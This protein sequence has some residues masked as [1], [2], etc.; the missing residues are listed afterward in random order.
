MRHSLRRP[1]VSKAPIVA[2]LADMDAAPSFSPSCCSSA[3]NLPL[4][5]FHI[6]TLPLSVGAAMYAPSHVMLT[7]CNAKVKVL[8]YPPMTLMLL[9]VPASH[10]CIV[11]SVA[12]ETT[13]PPSCDTLTANTPPLCPCS[14][15]VHL[16]DMRSH[17]ITVLSLNPPDTASVPSLHMA[18]SPTIPVCPFI[19]TST[20]PVSTFHTC[21]V[22]S[23]PP[24]THRFPSSDKLTPYRQL[25]NLLS[26]GSFSTSTV[27]PLSTFHT[28]TV[29]SLLPDARSFP[30]A[31]KL[32][33]Q[34]M[35][36]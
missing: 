11:L 10:T 30:P 7:E 8:E 9:P 17:I 35:S 6:H 16:P 24:A 13:R 19:S 4:S 25:D 20:S 29:L 15:L 27:S 3:H 28:L 12:P 26:E 23:E 21:T 31:E 32:K 34:M 2:P 14:T 33:A 1:V 18:T 5:T 36:L 22:P